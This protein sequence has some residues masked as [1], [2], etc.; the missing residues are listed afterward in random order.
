MRHGC[1]LLPNESKNSLDT[2]LHIPANVEIT[3]CVIHAL[4]TALAIRPPCEC[5]KGTSTA[6]TIYSGRGRAY[7][8]LLLKVALW[9]S[10]HP[11]CRLGTQVSVRIPTGT[12]AL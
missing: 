10:I 4:I 1:P 9:P 12:D 7:T 5:T 3:L 6:V 8:T 11:T 2:G